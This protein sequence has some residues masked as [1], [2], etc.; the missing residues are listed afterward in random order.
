MAKFLVLNRLEDGSKI[1]VNVDDI[2]AFHPMYDERKPGTQLY[3][4]SECNTDINDVYWQVQQS[5][6]ELLAMVEYS[7]GAH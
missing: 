6:M 1:A 5:F 4:R 2:S 3:M 7:S